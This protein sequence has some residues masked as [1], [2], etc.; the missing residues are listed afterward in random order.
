MLENVDLFA[1]LPADTMQSLQKYAV[2]RHYPKNT[3]IVHEDQPCHE[4]YIILSGRVK[5]FVSSKEGKQII[6]NVLDSGDYFGELGLI[7]GQPRSASVM[8]AAKTHLL[9]IS[10][11]DFDKFLEQHSA[12]AMNMMKALVKR[13]RFLTDSVSDLALLDV[14]GRIASLLQDRVSDVNGC[15]SPKPTHQEIADRVGASREMVSR[16]MRELFLG[17]YLEQSGSQ[18]ILKKPFPKG[19]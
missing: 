8:T 18:L 1:N 14:Y 16:I 19:W 12:A 5:V 3:L 7:D 15:I 13:I 2:E 17:G 10:Q 11:Q 9:A 4:F 6:L